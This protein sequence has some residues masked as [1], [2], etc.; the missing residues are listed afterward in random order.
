[1]NLFKEKTLIEQSD[2][3]VR[4]M[5]KTWHE[6]CIQKVSF[7]IEVLVGNRKD[8]KDLSHFRGELNTAYPHL[9]E[10]E[11]RLVLWL[12]SF[13][14]VDRRIITHELGHWVL[15][16]KGYRSLIYKDD[17]NLDIFLNSLCSHPQL[18]SLQKSLGHN[19]Q[20]II[21]DRAKSNIDVFKKDKEPTNKTLIIKN[22]LILADDFINCSENVKKNLTV[23]LFYN[24]Q[25]TLKLVNKIVKLK[26]YYDLTHVSKN[27][28]FM[29]KII[30]IINLDIGKWLENDNIK[31]LKELYNKSKA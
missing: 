2:E 18:Y 10:N 20:D 13:S 3:P 28:N 15:N 6:L 14:N 5:L 7:D 16:L 4:K 12:D 23:A 25:S 8:N 17:R 21:D 29:K 1:M 19:P 26:Q 27:F 11:V 22:A 31:E 24:H 30:Q 9:I